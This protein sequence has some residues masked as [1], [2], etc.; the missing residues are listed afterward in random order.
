MRS[1]G[2]CSVNNAPPDFAAMSDASFI[3]WLCVF[4][5]DAH[6]FKQT[7]PILGRLAAIPSHLESMEPAHV[8]GEPNAEDPTALRNNIVKILHKQYIGV[9]PS[10]Q[11]AEKATDA[12][13]LALTEF[14]E[15]A[16]QTAAGG[17]N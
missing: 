16:E 6:G 7:G 11:K 8:E 10:K 5:H 12:V 14:Y 17:L 2:A 9:T 4:L 13:L 1:C 15:Q 3:K